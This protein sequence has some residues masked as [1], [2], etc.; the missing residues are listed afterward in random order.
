MTFEN[1]ITPLQRAEIEIG[2]THP[3][4]TSKDQLSSL[5]V[6]ERLENRRE[7]L[8]NSFHERLDAIALEWTY[9]WYHER[10]GLPHRLPKELAHRGL[11]K[12]QQRSSY[13]SDWLTVDNDSATESMIQLQIRYYAWH[14]DDQY[15]LYPE[16]RQPHLALWMRLNDGTS[17][18]K[19]D[20][21]EVFDF[22]G[23]GSGRGSCGTNR[24][25]LFKGESLEFHSPEWAKLNEL[26][27]CLEAAGVQEP[28]TPI[29]KGLYLIPRKPQ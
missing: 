6:A 4:D 16:R 20:A 21:L 13:G 26:M 23:A 19:S 9:P 11:Q 7:T 18:T 15:E 2:R 29:N 5:Y 25:I 12:N 24:D 1:F 3:P 14:S 10:K 17:G 27:E 28:P 8:V 22:P